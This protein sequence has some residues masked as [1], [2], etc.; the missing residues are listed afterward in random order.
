MPSTGTA[1]TPRAIT[2]TYSNA[3]PVGSQSPLTDVITCR[4]RSGGLALGS[5]F[6]TVS[7][8]APPR[9]AAPAHPRAPASRLDPVAS[10]SP[11]GKRTRRAGPH[12]RRCPTSTN[13]R[14][15]ARRRPKPSPRPSGR[16]SKPC[17][18]VPVR[19]SVRVI[20]MTTKPARVKMF[21]P[22]RMSLVS[23]APAL[24]RSWSGP[25]S[26]ENIIPRLHGRGPTRSRRLGNAASRAMLL[27]VR[28]DIS[29]EPPFRGSAW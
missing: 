9:P 15:T 18:P 8:A 26:R 3:T 21:M 2:L 20:P 14:H 22:K 1:T 11:C 25:A 13:P 16:C 23:I 27:L 19:F 6:L 7:D 28:S 24:G 12:G 10:A 5:P 4:S 17:Q 29:K